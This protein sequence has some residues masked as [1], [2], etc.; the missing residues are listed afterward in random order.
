M[1]TLFSSYTLGRLQ[2]PNRIVMSPMTRSR[3]IGNVPNELV[4]A[5]YAQRASA[6]LIVTEGT[7]PSPNGLGY[8]RIPG[9]YSDAQI[10]GWRGVTD[11]VRAAGGRIF[12]QLMHTGRVAHPHNLPPGARIVAPSA[13][14]APGTMY[15]DAAGPQPH[16]VP[17]AMTEADIGAAR[18]EFVHAARSAIAAGADGIE[19]HAA[20]GYLLEQFLNTASNQRTDAYG[21]GVPQRARFVLEVARAVA[22]AIGGDRTG[23][24][25]S[26]YGANGGM[27]ADPDTDALYTHL[28]TELGK[29]GLVY[30]HVVDHAAMGAPPVPAAIKAAIRTAFRGAYILAGGY[31]RARAEA[32]LAEAKGDLVAFGRPFLAN[33]DLVG[34]LERGI[35]LR[36]PDPATFFTPG[37][38]GYT[39]WPVG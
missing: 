26:P 35:A 31:D 3:S 36:A 32:E 1:T 7:A 20:N 17:E 14:A 12:V 13:I 28:A 29:I 37:A 33:P 23:I 25:L 8:A 16:P 34:K 38:Q 30:I 27:I 15:T 21:G 18:A 9:I 2:L 4:A 6:G 24:R 22:D 39:D 10:A 19:L 11:A 5:Y